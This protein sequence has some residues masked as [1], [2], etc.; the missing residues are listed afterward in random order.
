MTTF[1][2]SLLPPQHDDEEDARPL[3][4]PVWRT[5][6]SETALL[7]IGTLVVYLADSWLDVQL[8]PEQ[9]TLVTALLAL[10][11]VGL[12][13][14][15]SW[16][17]ER[18]AQHP[19]RDLPVVMVVSALV[20]NAVGAPFVEMFVQP[21]TWLS[22]ASGLTRIVGYALTVGLAFETLKYLLLRYMTW[23]RRFRRRLDCVAYSLAISLAFA[24]VLNLRFALLEGGAQPGLAAIRITSVILLH[25]GAGL[26]VGYRL[27]TLKFEKARVFSLGFSLLLAGFL[28]GFYTA[29][30]A[31]LVVASFGIGASGNTPLLGFGFSVAFGV[32]LF[33]VYAFL[34]STAEARDV[35]SPA[36]G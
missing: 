20:A 17:G 12:W 16:R 33:A 25:E 13:L 28:H 22:A 2:T 18:R 9:R 35:R 5:V 21:E 3:F 27:M 19:R 32:A 4:H 23:P 10:L 11:P 15:F 26:V 7:V 36:T 31:G 30:R 24:T 8:S 34:I 14:L 6:V 29:F 1:D